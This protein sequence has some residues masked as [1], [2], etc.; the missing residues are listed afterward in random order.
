MK[1]NYILLEILIFCD[2]KVAKQTEDSKTAN[3]TGNKFLP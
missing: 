3:R 2:H 1:I